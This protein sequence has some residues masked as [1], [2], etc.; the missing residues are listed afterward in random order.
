V[1]G[2][3]RANDPVLKRIDELVDQYTKA[4]SWDT[5]AWGLPLCD[6][7]LTINFWVHSHHQ[8]KKYTLDERHP[9]VAALFEA[10]VKDLKILFAVNSEPAVA[11]K[12]R[13]H[14]GAAMGTHGVHADHVMHMVPFSKDDLLQGR[15]Q[16]RGGIA[17]QLDWWS[18]NKSIKPVV[19]DS[20]HGYFKI[21]RGGVSGSENYSGFIMTLNREI[22]MLRH[23]LDASNGGS[24]KNRFHSSYTDGAMTA[25]AGTILIEHGRIKAIRMDSG[26]YMPGFHNLG[27]FLMALRMYGVPLDK[28]ALYSYDNRLVGL[29]PDFLASN[30]RW[31]V[32]EKGQ[33][34]AL[35]RRGELGLKGPLP[36]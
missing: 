5:A 12:M 29:A 27:G 4:S 36:H 22:F 1:F 33:A 11:N 24:V 8:G 3:T 19:A 17:Y 26:H 21:L 18:G 30:A 16:F 20:K 7:F 23:E 10:T 25:M 14:F 2:A 31:D 13:E 32:Y 34:T 35:V 28:V 6:L 9:A 15:L